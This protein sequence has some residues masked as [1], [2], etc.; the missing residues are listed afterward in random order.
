MTNVEIK[1]DLNDLAKELNTQILDVTVSRDTNDYVI[2]NIAN[3]NEAA[4]LEFL[5][6]LRDN[7]D[8]DNGFFCYIANNDIVNY[9]KY[10]MIMRN[11]V[12]EEICKGG[13]WRV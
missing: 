8:A 12:P 11:I 9:Q 7:I 4:A 1:R 10:V 13:V 3:K 6:K 5:V 2:V